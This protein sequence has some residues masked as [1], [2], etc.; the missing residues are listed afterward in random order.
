MKMYSKIILF[1]CFLGV[2][3]DYVN[4]S[5][6][7]KLR[8]KRNPNNMLE[9]E[10]KRLKIKKE[11]DIIWLEKCPY[12][13]RS[14][15]FSKLD[16]NSLLKTAEL[17]KVLYKDV[18]DFVFYK[19]ENK[20][21]QLVF[22]AYFKEWELLK[23]KLNEFKE[24]TI[25]VPY[26]FKDINPLILMIENQAPVEI[27]ELMVDMYPHFLFIH[28]ARLT[29]AFTGFEN[30]YHRY[31]A[32]GT[33]LINFKNYE[34]EWFYEVLDIIL[35]INRDFLF[36]ISEFQEDYDDFD[37]YLHWVL[38]TKNMDHD[39]K[40]D[41]LQQFLTYGANLNKL[42]NEEKT[43]LHIVIENKMSLDFIVLLI[44][45]DAV[46]D[47]DIID[48]FEQNYKDQEDKTEY[49]EFLNILKVHFNYNPEIENN[50]VFANNSDDFASGLED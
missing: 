21:G 19:L 49:E 20:Q 50:L 30:S 14:K 7:K 31:A 48:T 13:L 45:A 38:K 3:H 17:N 34:K 24:N 6:R 23:N 9:R 18:C 46:V 2:S 12:S 42:N 28:N 26:E 36:R 40:I 41:V 11:E 29:Y 32:L 27:I 5:I 35:S 8:K 10:L 1:L 4:A 39:T 47:Q 33:L 37:S 43:P 44:D 25:S 15:I 22:L 16:L